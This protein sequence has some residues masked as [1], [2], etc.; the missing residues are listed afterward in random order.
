MFC[1]VFREG[2]VFFQKLERQVSMRDELLDIL[3][4]W[5]SKGFNIAH[6]SFHLEH[7]KGSNIL[8]DSYFVKA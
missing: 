5:A 1:N 2:R 3:K 8:S 4:S 7:R 6:Y